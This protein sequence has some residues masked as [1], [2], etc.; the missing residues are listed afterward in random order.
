MRSVGIVVVIGIAV[1]A[2]SC[3]GDD[4]STAV[5]PTLA[6]ESLETAISPPP[7]STPTIP[8]FPTILPAHEP[9]GWIVF[10][11][12]AD[13][14]VA[15]LDGSQEFAL[16]EGA[17]GSHFAGI[18]RTAGGG[19]DLYYTVLTGIVGQEP[20]VESGTVE[21]RRRPLAARAS[22]GI[23]VSMQ[24]AGKEAQRFRHVASNA[25]VSPDG[26]FLAY[27]DETGLWLRDLTAE[28]SSSLLTNNDGDDCDDT[29][30]GMCRSFREPSWSPAGD[31][32]VLTRGIYEGAL[33][34]FIRP[35]E[36]ITEYSSDIGALWRRWNSDGTQI[37]GSEG[38]VQ[39]EGW[40]VVKPGERTVREDGATTLA[41]EYRDLDEELRRAGVQVGGW[42]TAC[43]WAADGRIAMQYMHDER[44]SD[45][46]IAVLAADGA[47]VAE[48][49][50]PLNQS[51]LAGWLPDQSG[52]ILVY[53][54]GEG[55]PLSFIVLMDGSVHALAVKTDDVIAV[56]PD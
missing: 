16:T 37:C 40:G 23:V 31:W 6:P 4:R 27:A 39:I 47:L 7:A 19:R 26:R 35:P 21:V 32:L 49:D 1:A 15:K 42:I 41:G 45:Q 56:F 52:F 36:P 18:A 20:A 46:R 10:H 17:L 54:D 55:R 22:D 53:G 9:S 12:G 29:S 8:P 3:D 5:A 48:V 14:W 2:L 25:S 13:L 24:V 38:R 11:R 34:D 28:T 30:I 50:P 33:A 51:G 43:A 44:G